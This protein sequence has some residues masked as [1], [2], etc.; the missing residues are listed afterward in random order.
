MCLNLNDCQFIASRYK[1]GSTYFHKSKTYNRFTNTEKKGT[2]AYNKRKTT[3]YK[4]KNKK[5]KR[6]KKNY[7]KNWKTRIRMAISTYL[8]IITLNVNVLNA[9]IKDRVADWIKKQSGAPAVVQQDWQHL[10]STGTW[11]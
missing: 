1:Y 9:S 10:G 2:Q 5:K 4:R 6:T 7:K 3:S 8:S 11:V